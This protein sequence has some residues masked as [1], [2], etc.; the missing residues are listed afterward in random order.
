MN[1]RTPRLLSL[2]LTLAL[3]GGAH[4]ATLAPEE[5][6][7]ASC[8]PGEVMEASVWLINTDDEPL[9]VLEAK[10]TCGCTSLIGFAPQTLPAGAALEV[11]L[12]V[13]APKTA[14]RSKAV[15]VT[16]TVKDRSPL[17]L[18]IRVE[19][20]GSRPAPGAITAAPPVVDLGRVTAEGRAE[21]MVRLTNTTAAPARVT[22]AKAGCGCITFPDFSPF[23]LD[24]GA[25]ADVRMSVKAPSVV[26]RP[27]TKDVTFVVADHAPVKVPVRIQAA[28]PLAEALERYLGRSETDDQ[29]GRWYGDFR[30]EADTV[31][32]IIWAGDSTPRAR[33]VC[34]FDADGQVTAI[35]VEPI[36]TRPAVIRSAR[37]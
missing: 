18:P 12:R 4:A 17:T 25:S 23:E 29:A 16:V 37:R 10:A 32:A 22:G 36:T 2:L 28:H 8:A 27:R 24:S 11:A 9:E 35:R 19:T 26:G 15:S 5:L 1:R 6:H 21:S 13:T 33:L 14:G 30:V 31:S 7:F 34:R 3:V 20:T